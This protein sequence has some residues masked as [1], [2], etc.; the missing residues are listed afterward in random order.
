MVEYRNAALDHAFA[1]LAHPTRR[2]I[3]RQLSSGPLTVNEVAA[4]HRISL[5]AVSKH[6]DVLEQAGLLRRTKEGRMQRC[7]LRGEPLAETARWVEQ[8]RGFWEMQLGSLSRYLGAR[9][10][11]S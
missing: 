4:A 9:R 1:A 5:A 11:R 2:T 6:L 3:V 8:Y 7:T 10:H